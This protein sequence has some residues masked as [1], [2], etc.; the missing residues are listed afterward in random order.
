MWDN[1]RTSGTQRVGWKKKWELLRTWKHRKRS[2]K[3][4]LAARGEAGGGH[5]LGDEGTAEIQ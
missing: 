4:E 5:L 1:G 2:G 3:R